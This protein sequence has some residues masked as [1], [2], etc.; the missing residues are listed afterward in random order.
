[1]VEDEGELY[2]RA[3]SQINQK[4]GDG[5]IYAERDPRRQKFSA[6]PKRDFR[7]CVAKKRKLEKKFFFGDGVVPSFEL[8]AKAR[9]SDTSE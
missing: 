8:A 2:H 3:Q 6:S 9:V 1:M 5:I 4:I 7:S